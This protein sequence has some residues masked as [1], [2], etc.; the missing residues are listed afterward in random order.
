[1]TSI[2]Y[3]V[4]S[5]T[6]DNEKRIVSGHYDC[7]LS[8]LGIEQLR[9]LKEEI[10]EFNPGVIYSSPL[11]RAKETACSLFPDHPILE[12]ERLIEIDYGQLT[13]TP[14]DDIN[15]LKHLHIGNPFPQGESYE[16]VESRV[17]SF[18]QSMIPCEL[19]TIISHQAPQLALDVICKGL[20]WEQAFENDWR[21]RRDGWKPFWIYEYPLVT[22]SYN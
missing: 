11:I 19:I 14:H 12:D 22:I 9:L 21:L 8:P 4:Y 15:A 7:L 3:I 17:Y 10:R 5:T 2:R 6:V 18:L 16:D 13:H 20:S 1:M